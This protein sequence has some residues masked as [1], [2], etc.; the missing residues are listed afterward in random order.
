VV[1]QPTRGIGER[2]LQQIRDAARGGQVSLWRAAEGILAASALA[3]RAG[4]AVRGFLEL[5]NTL[6]ADTKTLSLPEQVE[7]VVE[8]STL[9][10]HFEKDR[11]EKGQSRVENLEELV[12]AARAHAGEAVPE[13]G[14]S[15]LD[16]FLAHAALESGEGQGD[17]WEDCVQLM[18]LHSAKGLEFPL[19]FLSGLEE[20]LFPSER[21]MEEPG[22]LEEERRLAY[23]GITRAEERLYVSHA[24]SRR[25]YGRDHFSSPSRFIGEIP[26]ALMQEV[27]PKV[28]V[29]RP[30]YAAPTAHNPFPDESVGFRIGQSVLHGKFGS[31]VVLDCEGTGSHARVQVNFEEAGP[32]W[33][34]L[35]YA[36]L[37]A[38]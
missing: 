4:N 33:L 38:V 10:A 14:L 31:G 5:I 11:S 32:K 23:V 17:A 35:A 9:K 3:A 16:G 21:A 30:V 1:N 24:E 7:H 36:N 28:Q 29:T 18:T 22:R 37:Q 25:L 26:A 19:V 15:P 20:G 13:E 12:S 8:A 34:V 27:R 2:T 6:D